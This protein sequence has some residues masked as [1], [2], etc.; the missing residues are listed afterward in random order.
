MHRKIHLTSSKALAIVSKLCNSKFWTSTY[1]RLK[2][3]VKPGV[4]P[5]QHLK[6]SPPI[7]YFTKTILKRNIVSPHKENIYG[8]NS[9]SPTELRHSFFSWFPFQNVGRND[10]PP[11]EQYT[12][13]NTNRIMHVF[14]RNRNASKTSKTAS[15]K[16]KQVRWKTPSSSIPQKKNKCLTSNTWLFINKINKLTTE[17]SFHVFCYVMFLTVPEFPFK[18]EQQEFADFSLIIKN[19]HK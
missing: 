11:A 2:S 4:K 6:L 7:I 9:W 19:Y 15:S 5:R 13:L 16:E 12:F 3:G 10:V 17:I 8:R 18:G 1:T 14:I